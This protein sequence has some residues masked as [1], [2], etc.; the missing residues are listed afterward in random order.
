MCAICVRECNVLCEVSKSA[1]RG[2]EVLNPNP[3][4]FGKS[5]AAPQSMTRPWIPSA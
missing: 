1:F 2:R 4:E 5:A 3:E